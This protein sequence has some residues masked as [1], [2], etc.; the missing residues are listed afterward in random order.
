MFF[1]Q[2]YVTM[3][4]IIISETLPLLRT[5]LFWCRKTRNKGIVVAYQL[6]VT[7][8]GRY[9]NFTSKMAFIMTSS[10]DAQS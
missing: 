4:R 3:M 8:R 2:F 6:L 7:L 10:F 1:C 9:C 5:I